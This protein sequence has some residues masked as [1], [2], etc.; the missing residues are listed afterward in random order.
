MK[1]A[2]IIIILNLVFIFS[3][4]GKQDIDEAQRTTASL[5]LNQINKCVVDLF[6]YNE[7]KNTGGEVNL[8]I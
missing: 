8:K 5:T 3:F 7:S 6:N 4:A 1:A 2:V